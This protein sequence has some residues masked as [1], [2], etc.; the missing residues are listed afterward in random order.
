M[1][2]VRTVIVSAAVLTFGTGVFC[3]EVS[4][5][6]PAELSEPERAAAEREAERLNTWLDAKY[7]EQLSFS[8]M[9]RAYNGDKAFNDQIDDMSEAAADRALDWHRRS[10]AELREGFDRSKLLYDAQL[11]YDLWLF[12]YNE[13]A[14]AAKFRRNAYV[15]NQMSGPHT[16]LPQ[17]L[18]QIHSVDVPA[19]LDAYVA[20]IGGIARA[21]QQ[22][23]DIARTNA[24]AGTRV[25]RFSYEMMTT[26]ARALITGAPFDDNGNSA[27]WEDFNTKVDRLSAAG[28][29]DAAEADAYRAAART[30]LLQHWK[31]AY[32]QLIAWFE[33]ELPKADGVATGVGKNPGGKAYYDMMLASATNTNLTADQIHQI[34]LDEVDRIKIEMESLKHKVGFKGTLQDFF[35]FVREDRQFYDADNDEGR[36]LHLDA[37]TDY[38]SFMKVRLP[39]YFGIIPKADV[40][41]KRVE[42]F[43]EV[44]G[45]AAHYSMSSPDGTRPGV[46]YLHLSDMNAKSKPQLESTVY[47]E[48]LPGHHLNFAIA[49]ELT[50]IP[51][52]RKYLYINAYQEGWGLYAEKLGKEMGGYTDPYSDFGRLTAEIWRAVRLVV[53]TGLHAKG[54]TEDDAVAYFTANSAATDGQIRSEV[55]R[56]IVM[57]GQATGYKIGMIKMEAFRKKAEDRLGKDFD[58]KGFHDAVLGSGQMSLDMLERHVDR[59]IE[60]QIKDGSSLAAAS[61]LDCREQR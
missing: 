9:A 30:A 57:P 5:A 51:N 54:W 60:G 34:G 10:V 20:R 6:G 61:R 7:E 1:N 39:D 42:P 52:F 38:V 37:A 46:F 36:K 32:Q 28:Q 47:H 8:P 12:Q 43:R 16:S 15:F 31:P 45:G 22:L 17:F 23:L 13:A 41:V 49:R 53:D 18:I 50:N 35:S 44:P 3:R 29:I 11:S 27:I 26:Q 40:V 21:L 19:D 33:S 55:Q 25:P 48:A 58:I 4:A 24:I 56:Y 2:L 14:A 59:W